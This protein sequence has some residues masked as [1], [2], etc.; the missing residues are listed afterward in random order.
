LVSEPS[1]E[2]AAQPTRDWPHG[3][4]ARLIFSP[5]CV[6]ISDDSCERNIMSDRSAVIPVIAIGALFGPPSMARDA[7]DR[8]VMEAASEIGFMTVSGLPADIPVDPATRRRML[9]L[10]TL[11]EAEKRKLWRQK[12][13][14]GQRNVYRGW[15]PLQEG[16][17]TYKEGI[18]IGPAVDP[19]DPLREASALPSESALPGW[20]AVAASYYRGM[21]RTACTLMRSIARRLGLEEDFFD[22]A[23]TAGGVATL[24]FIRYPLRADLSAAGSNDDDRDMWVT[25]RGE[26]RYLVGRGHVDSG[27]VTLLA[28]DG[29][30]GL[31]ARARDGSWID[32]P[33][34]EGT[35]A[36]NF[37]KVLE[38]WTG[39]R[40]KAT[41]HRV[42]GSG[43]ERFSIPFFYEPRVD[44]EIAPLP[45]PG[46]ASFTPFLFG[47]HLWATMTKFV[48]FHGLETLRQPRG[49]FVP[50]EPAREK[51]DY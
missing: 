36:V 48:E 4:S 9:Q 25:H 50:P 30:E 45:L 46:A 16:H 3:Q 29:V 2:Y 12:F 42:I 31:Q 19:G 41:E 18:D 20:R 15:F 37:G 47:D 49:A 28:Q 8:A 39:G 33:P 40:I 17:T 14:P 43:R 32:V 6:Q 35:L 7:A 10:F 21:E 11:P 34:V 26:R 22:D 24:R 44:A 5:K 23:F 38:R 27:L 51:V 13:D 1:D